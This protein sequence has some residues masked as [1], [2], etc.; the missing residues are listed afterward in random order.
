MPLHHGCAHFRGASQ[1]E[2]LGELDAGA[3][4]GN[5]IE[6]A[7]VY[8]AKNA[9]TPRSNSAMSWSWVSFWFSCVSKS[10]WPCT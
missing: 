6:P 8:V 3:L 5:G 1:E 4:L 10:P 2:P 9:A 7:K